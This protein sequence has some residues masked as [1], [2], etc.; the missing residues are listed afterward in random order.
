MTSTQHQRGEAFRD[1]HAHQKIFLMPNP[2]DKGSAVLLEKLGFEALASTSAG[3]AFSQGMPDGTP[4]FEQVLGHLRELCASTSL[5]VS[6]DLEAMYADSPEAVYRN[7]QRAA[8]CGIVGASIQDSGSDP[9]APLMPLSLAVERVQAAVEAKRA[10]DH[11]FVLT[12]RAE[13]FTQPDASMDDTLLRL[14]AYE[15][16]GADVLFAP[17]I[18]TEEQVRCVV[19][20]VSKPVSVMLGFAGSTLDVATLERLGVRRVST[21]G[22]FARAAYSAMMAAA[23]ELQGPGTF[24]QTGSAMTGKQFNELFSRP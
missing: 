19:A 11:P 8:A 3:F 10:L 18:K 9:G 14:Q 13:C 4:S 6:A 24:H 1:L 12:A 22:S 23:S 5:P 7:L 16:A 15:K 2:W 20:A 21:G 17:W